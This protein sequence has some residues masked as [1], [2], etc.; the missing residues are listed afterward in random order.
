MAK[1]RNDEVVIGISCTPVASPQLVELMGLT[2]FDFLWIDME[3]QNYSDDQVVAMCQACRAT[4]MEPMVRVRREGRHGCFR[5]Y[6]MGGTGIMV[7]HCMG[8]E[9]AASIVRDAR[10]S[11]V[12]L[13]GLDGIEP[14]AEYGRIPVRDYME[15]SNR[16][17]FLLIQIE[18]REAVDEIEEIAAQPGIDILFVGPGDL[19]QSYGFPG[20]GKCAPVMEAYEKVAKA[21][22]RH[23]KWWGAPG[24]TLENTQHLV[25]LGARFIT[26]TSVIGL[27][28]KGLEQV[29]SQFQDLRPSGALVATKDRTNGKG[30]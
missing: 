18:D 28:R 11:P 1:L 29:H 27:V 16:E 23:G 15:W 25:D 14:L 26:T 3:H 7:P 20:N 4:D 13:R 10:F 21:A 9:D 17:T 30:E 12:G 2:G 24:G 5:G 6:E 8:K 19:S 22:A